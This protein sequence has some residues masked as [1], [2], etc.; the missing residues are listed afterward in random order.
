[1]RKNGI[2]SGT[3]HFVFLLDWQNRETHP[4]NRIPVIPFPCSF[5]QHSK[6]F[7]FCFQDVVTHKNPYL[8]PC[9]LSPFPVRITLKK[10]SK[11]LLLPS[12][13]LVEH[14]HIC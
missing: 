13:Y 11:E 2:I 3:M 5:I 8:K 7:L 1:M 4:E 12:L 10:F 14:P 6:F 9:C